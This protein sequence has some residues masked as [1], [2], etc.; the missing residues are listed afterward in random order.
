M[1]SYPDHQQHWPE[2]W[3]DLEIEAKWGADRA[4]FLALHEK[5]STIEEF[6]GYK[7]NVRWRGRPRVFI[8]TYYDVSQ[9]G[10]FVLRE[11]MH[12]LRHR[13]RYDHKDRR[14]WDW[15][16]ADE[17][18]FDFFDSTR[19][20]TWDEEWHRLQY[21]TQ[22]SRIK[23]IWFRNEVGACK[24]YDNEGKGLCDGFEGDENSTEAYKKALTG[25]KPHPAMTVLA[26]DHAGLAINP[27]EHAVIH[28][29]DFR[30]RVEF[31]RVEEPENEGDDLKEIVVYELSL[32]H[33]KNTNLITG[34]IQ[35]DFEAELELVKPDKDEGRVLVNSD[36]SGLFDLVGAIE[37]EFK[38]LTMSTTTKGGVAVPDRTQSL[39]DDTSASTTGSANTNAAMDHTE[40]IQH[41]TP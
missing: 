41:Q 19:D 9:D 7:L 6:G 2:N 39:A 21:K 32:D 4:T 5:F 3:R 26:Q 14:N 23:A 22:P 18:L 31:I 33:L 24:L 10:R 12:N 16:P 28:V 1:A 17:G 38:D 13:R 27:D 25:E 15:K 40:Q 35:E 11:H 37:A 8:D 29:I 30:F 36:L 20:T 34:V